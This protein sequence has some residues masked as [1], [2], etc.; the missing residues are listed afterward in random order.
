MCGICA[1]LGIDNAFDILYEGLQ[2][3]Q[4]RG[5]DSAGICTINESNNFVISKYA[6]DSISAIDKLKHIK[7]EHVGNNNGIA[8][9][10]WATHGGKTKQN[11][12]PHCDMN[13]RISLVHNGIIENYKHIYNKLVKQGYK[14]KSGTDTEVIANLIGSF[15]DKNY[16]IYEAIVNATNIMKGTWALAIMFIN[17]PNKLY[18]S[19]NGSPLLVGIGDRHDFVIISSEQSGFNNRI[20]NYIIIDD[21]DVIII[22]KED[23][24]IKSYATR[25]QNLTYSPLSDRIMNSIIYEYIQFT[26]EPYKHW[27][28]KEIYEQPESVLRVINNG[29]R[30]RND[31]SVKLGGLERIRNKL[32]KINHLIIL[33]CGTSYNAGLI[34]KKYMKMLRI[35]KYVEVINPSEF[36]TYDIPN[37]TNDVGIL[38]ISQSGETRDILNAIKL[39]KASGITIFSIINSVN[40]T[41][42]RKSDAGIYLNAGREVGVAAT[43]TFTSQ[44][45]ALSLIAIWYAQF[46]NLYENKR[47]EIISNLRNLSSNISN[48]IPNITTICQNLSKFLKDAHT[49]FILGT[50]RGE[51]IAY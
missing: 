47:C 3:L 8:H 15:L 37:D 31:S 32:L 39:C 12:H 40:S 48:L 46:R 9:T 2:I 30:I 14:F 16:S 42:A 20:N 1:V 35:F 5:Y 13:N 51:P 33:A 22:S 17:E 28:I 19:K 4:N 25:G 44:C 43:K 36:D 34:G 24:Q 49:I 29:G 18:L 41:I 50:L 45:V 23:G 7:N 11:A 27:T 21:N 6:S 26:P 10:R 38:C